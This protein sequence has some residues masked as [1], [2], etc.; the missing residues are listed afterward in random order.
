MNKNGTKPWSF[1]FAE[2]ED[3]T[4]YRDIKPQI[5]RGKEGIKVGLMVDIPIL[6]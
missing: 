1:P 3:V 6:Q 2:L 5:R 4:G